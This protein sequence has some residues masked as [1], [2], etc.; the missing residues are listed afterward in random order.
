MAFWN[1]TLDFVE[2]AGDI[3]WPHYVVAVCVQDTSGRKT[4]SETSQAAATDMVEISD[5]PR[6]DLTWVRRL[7]RERGIALPAN[8]LTVQW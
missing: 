4:V 8:A 2:T 6:P 7:T 5:G 1:K 3:D